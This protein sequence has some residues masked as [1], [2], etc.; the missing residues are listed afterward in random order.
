MTVQQLKIGIISGIARSVE[1]DQTVTEES[2][3]V[4]QLGL[5][6][7]QIIIMLGDLEDALGIDIPI[8]RVADVETVGDLCE[9][10]VQLLTE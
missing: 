1:T 10:V 6:S 3:L 5:S 2:H 4:E 9:V 8:S 7:M